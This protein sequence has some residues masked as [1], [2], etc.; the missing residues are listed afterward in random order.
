MPG[1]GKARRPLGAG[2]SA[3]LLCGTNLTS[4][5]SPASTE[6][7]ADQVSRR[8]ERKARCARVRERPRRRTAPM[9]RI[10]W[11]SAMR[12][13]RHGDFFSMAI[14]GTMETPMPAPTMLR[15]LLNWPLSKTICGWRRA[16]WEEVRRI[17]GNNADGDGAADELFAF[18]D[19][20]FGGF[21]FA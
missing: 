5:K 10:A 4:D 20:A 3:V 8:W 14:S 1:Q 15:R 7:D 9:V 2:I 21:Q 12:M 17:G 19:V 13:Y 18:D 11:S 16:R 6:E